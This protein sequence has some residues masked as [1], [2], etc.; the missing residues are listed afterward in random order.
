MSFKQAAV[1]VNFASLHVNDLKRFEKHLYRKD[2]K[3]VKK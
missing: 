1:Q 2:C 3:L